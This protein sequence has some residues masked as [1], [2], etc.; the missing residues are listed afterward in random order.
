MV[1]RRLVAGSK[2]RGKA[3][4]AAK[5]LEAA[6]F[7]DSCGARRAYRDRGRIV[8]PMEE[9]EELSGTKECLALGPAQSIA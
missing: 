8:F 9:A 3:G 6:A 7:L 2:Y 1:R 4:E 5:H